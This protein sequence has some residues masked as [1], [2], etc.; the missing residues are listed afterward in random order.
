MTASGH[1]VD[2]D[3]L[4]SDASPSIVVLDGGLSTAL[5]LAGADLR[6]EMWT[7]RLLRDD[8]ESIVAAHRS[9]YDAGA[10]VA[11]TA[12]YQASVSGFEA[13][14]F[15]RA[16]AER[17]IASS[18]TLAKRAR[19]EA[20]SDGR[21]LLVAASV[22]PYGAVLADGSEYRGAYGLSASELRE[23]HGPRLE[24][25]AAAE[26]DLFAVETIPD[27]REAEVLVPLLDDVG[28]PAWFAYTIDSGR[29]RA[30]QSLAEAFD[31]VAGSTEIIAAGVNCSAPE[32]VT[33][34][35]QAAVAATG[36]AGVAYPNRGERWDAVANAWCGVDSFSL[37]LVPEW[38]EAGARYIGGCCRISPADIAML[39]SALDR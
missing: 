18:V 20:D 12:S 23:F 5:E 8:P 13:V 14:G 26:P 1:G 2:H 25:L 38:L 15:G 35:V 31:V 24:L 7:A 34:A 11:T 16:E 9:Y 3:E 21:R 19:D 36:V 30:G 17:L 6:T 10:D 4:L 22:G 37:D 27:V 29:T 32:E 39:A 28:L 33:G